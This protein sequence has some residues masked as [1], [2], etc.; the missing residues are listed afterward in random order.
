[1]TSIAIILAYIS[2]IVVWQWRRWAHERDAQ[3]FGRL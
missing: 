2:A 3:K 1:M